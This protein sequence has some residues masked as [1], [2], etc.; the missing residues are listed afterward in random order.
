MAWPV[1]GLYGVE[2]GAEAGGLLAVLGDL[3][4]EA[5]AERFLAAERLRRPRRLALG[6]GEGGSGLGD[7]SRQSARLLVRRVRSSS[8]ACSFTRF[9]ICSCIRAKKDT[10]LGLLKENGIGR[11]AHARADRAGT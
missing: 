8:T 2:L 6:G 3:A 4:L 11:A 5:G 1:R 7:F 10:A 9:S